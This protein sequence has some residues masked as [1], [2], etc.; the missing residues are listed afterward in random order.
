L[1]SLAI[2][3]VP[4]PAGVAALVE[5]LRELQALAVSAIAKP[6]ETTATC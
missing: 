2:G 4:E 3:V 1:S 6:I 5:L